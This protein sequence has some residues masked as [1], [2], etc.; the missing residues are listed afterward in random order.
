[1]REKFGSS[2]NALDWLAA[3]PKASSAGQ[4][5]E[6]LSRI[7]TAKGDEHVI[8]QV[9][10]KCEAADGINDTGKAKAELLRH[11]SEGRC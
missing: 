1:V 2:W 8:R 7:C 10:A 4:G 3:F 9:K 11:C 6:E 5:S